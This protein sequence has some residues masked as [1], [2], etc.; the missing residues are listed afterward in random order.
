MGNPVRRVYIDHSATTPLDSRVLE[1]M[2]PFYA[3]RFGNASSVHAFGRDARVTLERS[4]EILAKFLNAEIGEIFF[5]SGGTESDNYAIK[6]VAAPGRSGGPAWSGNIIIRRIS[7]D[8]LTTLILLLRPAPSL[9]RGPGLPG[10]GG[11]RLS[12]RA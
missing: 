7:G 3:E 12:K 11:C 4:R 9:G 2:V 1:A 5:T 10:R 8:S 6:G